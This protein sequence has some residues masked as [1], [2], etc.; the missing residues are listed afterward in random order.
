MKASKRLAIELGVVGLL[1]AAGVTA[2]VIQRQASSGG[3]PISNDQAGLAYRIPDGY[4]PEIITD[5]ERKIG[6]VVKLQRHDPFAQISV[7]I[8]T[9]MPMEAGLTNTNLTDFLNQNVAELYRQYPEFHQVSLG[10]AKLLGQSGTKLVFTYLGT[11]Q[12]TRMR[13]AVTGFVLNNKPYFVEF[14]SADPDFDKLMG[15]FTAFTAAA[16][17]L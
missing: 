7:R 10:T 5:A 14:Q 12:Q 15:V 6:M 4:Q 1:L 11:D 13:M 9:N 16:K 8:D 3:I 2:Y 17:P